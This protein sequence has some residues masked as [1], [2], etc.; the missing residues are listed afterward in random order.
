MVVPYTS[1]PETQWPAIA[2]PYA[3]GVLAV[4]FQLEQTQWWSQAELA[5]QQARQ[6]KV[7][8]DHA[9]RTVPFY[10]EKLDSLNLSPS[11]ATS[12][13]GWQRIP[14]LQKR[15]VQI[16]G[17][18]LHS[19]AV[20]KGHGD[21]STAMTSGSTGE[22]TTVCTTGLTSFF[23]RVFALRDH[24][25]HRRDFAQPFA[26]IRFVPGQEAM[27]PAG[28]QVEHW[29][30]PT[31][32]IV[33]SGRGHVLNLKSSIEEQAA[34][35]R[36]VN[37]GYVLA[38]PCVL[39]GV[40]ELFESRSWTLPRLQELSTFG[41]ILEPRC[42][43]VC[44][45]VFGVKVVDTYSSEEAGC[46]AL[47][48]PDH[49]HYHVQSENVLIEVLDE[50]G[51]PC[52]P[53]QTGKVVL[54]TLHNFAMP[55]LRYEI[56]DY[57]EVGDACPCGRGLL[58]LKRIL[59]RSRNLLVMPNGERRPPVFTI[60]DMRELPPFFQYQIV[61]RS[62]EEI[63]LNV[64]RPTAGLTVEEHAVVERFVQQSLGYPFK[65]TINCVEAI[66]RNPTGKFEV[67][68]SHVQ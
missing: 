47:Q 37:P 2:E 39:Q 68:I 50:A 51:Q 27:P 6:L 38:Y 34:W 21:V 24:L 65:V 48:C 11:G 64:V 36:Y 55:L 41:E 30:A 61:Q 19:T 7:V 53:G 32:N 58:V 66:P 16:A 42:R 31:N 43:A 52:T 26:A 40:A 13:E 56:G 33:P 17:S 14:L 35:L 20:P 1:L 22:P 28:V 5:V 57:A 63:E 18:S 10:R 60:E 59:G 15:D 46:I 4:L 67:F 62:V 45:R 8:V 3:A 9:Y 54:T 44:Q 23:W 29:G 12:A 49:E 25:W